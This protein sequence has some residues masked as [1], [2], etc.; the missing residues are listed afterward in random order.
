MSLFN[1]KSPVKQGRKRL[2]IVD[3][4]S[5]IRGRIERSLRHDELEYVGGASNG[6]LAV[7]EF[8]RLLPDV[9]TMD[10]T[11]PEM[12]GIACIEA[13][14]KIKPDVLI[15]VVSALTDMG[16]AVK[17]LERGA[18]GFLGKPFNDASLN[19]ALAELLG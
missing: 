1:R 18:H 6:K 5:I 15:L 8:T 14:L 10:I 2:F 9:V 17:A 3:D 12:D 7:I 13:I 4:S 16:M 19:E 11:M